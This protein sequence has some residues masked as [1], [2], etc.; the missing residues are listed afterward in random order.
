MKILENRILY[1]AAQI[2]KAEIKNCKGID[3]QPLA[4][5]ELT[6]N[7]AKSFIPTSLMKLLS[8]VIARQG[9]SDDV[10]V[11]ASLNEADEKRSYDWSRYSPLGHT[12]KN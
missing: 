4:T 6:L 5:D 8:W 9:K 2:I 7:R 10:R 3:I 11:P 12:W 1:H